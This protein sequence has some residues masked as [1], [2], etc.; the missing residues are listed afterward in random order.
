MRSKKSCRVR[1]KSAKK[2]NPRSKTLLYVSRWSREKRLSPTHTFDWKWTLAGFQ[3]SYVCSLCNCGIEYVLLPKGQFRLK[4]LLEFRTAF[5]RDSSDNES[6]SLGLDW[7]ST[8]V[9]HERGIFQRANGLFGINSFTLC[10][11]M[12]GK[13]M[14]KHTQGFARCGV[15]AAR[16]YDADYIS[17]IWNETSDELKVSENNW[18]TLFLFKIAMLLLFWKK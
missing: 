9:R 2:T 11:I 1:K 16:C 18:I 6:K 15:S 4:W 12:H 8:S 14:R 17:I 7:T 10:T 5:V 3:P 13:T